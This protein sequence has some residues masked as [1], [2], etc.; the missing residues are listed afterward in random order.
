M[1]INTGAWFDSGIKFTTL[2]RVSADIED[3]AIGKATAL[4][5]LRSTRSSTLCG[6]AHL[7]CQYAQR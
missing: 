4:L 2:F 3:T 5:A 1:P 6:S 7:A